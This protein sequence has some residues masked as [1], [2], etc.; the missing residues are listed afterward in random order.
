MP[1]PRTPAHLRRAK[2]AKRVQLILVAASVAF[3]L[4]RLLAIF[5]GQNPLH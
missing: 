5:R 2:L 1:A 4:Y 3:A